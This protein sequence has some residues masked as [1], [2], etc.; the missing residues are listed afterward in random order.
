MHAIARQNIHT[1][2]SASIYLTLS[3]MKHFYL[4]VFL[5]IS[6][7]CSQEKKKEKP[8]TADVVS[9]QY[10]ILNTLPHDRAAFTEGLL[11][12]KNKIYEST[13]QPGQSW[14]AEV[15]PDDGKTN[16]KIIL[17]EPYFG[18]GITILN[19]KIYQLTY[20]T[21]NGFVYDA[22]TYKKIKEFK[23]DPI[24]KQGWGLTH[25]TKHLIWSDGTDKIHFVDT[26][27][28]KVV[29]SITVVQGDKK[30]RWINELEYVDNFI[31]A[32]VWQ[33]NTIIKINP[34]TGKVVGVLDLQKIA[35]E[36]ARLSPNAEVLNGIAFDKN[37]RALLVTGKYWTKMYVIRIY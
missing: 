18:E 25:D 31:F 35:E 3:A 12:Y 20:T 6:V 2:V 7:S 24:I 5:A 30:V 27:T 1:M 26:T 33:T 19:N 21:G 11:I 23:Y 28:L 8:Q 16:K 13:G 22:S 36:A 34:T 10:N 32:N 29:K 14:I 17:P 37:A 4:L 15:N 9:I